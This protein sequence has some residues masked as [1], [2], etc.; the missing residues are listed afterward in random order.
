[1]MTSYAEPNST[2][3]VTP[4]ITTFMATATEVTP[5]ATPGGSWMTTCESK[6]CEMC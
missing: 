4:V 5:G 6:N 1:M 2:L 3:P